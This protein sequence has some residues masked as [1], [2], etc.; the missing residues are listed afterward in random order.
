MVLGSLK[1]LGEFAYNMHAVKVST[2]PYLGA[3]KPHRQLSEIALPWGRIWSFVS[4]IFL[5]IYYGC[6]SFIISLT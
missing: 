6:D 2:N 4:Q 1:R 5:D 3:L